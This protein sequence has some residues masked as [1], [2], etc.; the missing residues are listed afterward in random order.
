MET[1]LT[2]IGAENLKSTFYINQKI[3]QTELMH[4]E[5]PRNATTID[6]KRGFVFVLSKFDTGFTRGFRCFKKVSNSNVAGGIKLQMLCSYIILIL[7][8]F[9]L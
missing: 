8:E 7:T 6:I 5:F 1:I 3:F 4:I 9:Y 2:M